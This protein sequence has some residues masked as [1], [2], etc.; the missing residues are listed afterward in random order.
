M[1]RF[2]IRGL[3]LAVAVA[4]SAC[5]GGEK[6]AKAPPQELPGQYGVSFIV[7]VSR[8]SGGAIASQDGRINCGTA[9][10]GRDLCAPVSFPWATK[11]T[12]T[13]TADAGMYFQSWAADCG[14]SLASTCVLDTVSNGADKTV[15]AF[16]N[17][18]ERL[19]HGNVLAP[20]VHAPLYFKFL[21]SE[22]DAP[23]CTNCHGA[24]YAGVGIA[25][26]C[27][28]CHAAAGWADWQ[29]SCSF[30]HGQK[31]AVTKAG[32][33]FALHPE[34]AAPPDDVQ[35][36][37]TGTNGAAAGA[38]QRH[39]TG[40]TLRGPL[41][42]SECH[43]VPETAIH[44]LN[45]SLDLPFGPLA[46]GGGTLK[47]VWTASTLTCASTWCHGSFKNGAGANP[48]TWTG[49]AAACGSCHGVPPAGTHPGVSATTAC[50]GCHPGYT[51]TS[52]NL[53]THVNGVIDAAGG[54]CDSCHGFPPATGAHLTHFGLTSTQGTSGY[55]DLRV[56][57]DF[58]GSATPT[59]APAMYAFGCGN[60][61]PVDPARHG[62]N[63][64]STVAKVVLND[65]SGTGGMKALNATTAAYDAGAK[66][67][68]GVY[69]HSS[70][71][72]APTYVTTPVWTST[73][74][75]GCAGCH[76][77]PPRYASG[78]GGTATANSHVQLDNDGWPWGHF[79]LPM[80]EY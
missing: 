54:A 11:V 15:L 63:D 32:Y 10:T 26:S 74:K 42:C 19:G 61:H 33:D 17:P 41:P 43:V 65:G 80:T 24:N 16:F 45:A 25:P 36:R 60:C 9:G 79:G 71:Q 8:P 59:S 76:E 67:C 12:L 75:I 18:P 6:A 7:T 20:S 14:P 13:A 62:M 47:P 39:L 30:C 69:C 68:S 52:V 53:A 77:N 64:G 31:S 22:P 50:S 73:E 46:T 2:V 56:L 27:N 40:S 34:W 49:G 55:G 1:R 37:L 66:T 3:A 72:A 5:G 21:G 57:E 23:R 44:P 35:G 51:R 4:V 48:V 28:A 29:Q 78:G 70:G 38:H 58:F